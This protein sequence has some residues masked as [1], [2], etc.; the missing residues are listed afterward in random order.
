MAN[1]L[2]RISAMKSAS[3][4]ILLG[5]LWAAPLAA[6]PASWYLWQSRLDGKLV[7]LQTSPGDGWTL[8]KGPFKDNNCRH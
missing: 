8:V 1:T 3:R 5:I 2:C 4:W 7:C 6:A